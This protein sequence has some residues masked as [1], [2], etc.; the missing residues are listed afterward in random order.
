[1][2]LVSSR[3]APFPLGFLGFKVWGLGLRNEGLG[4]KVWGS[5]FRLSGSGFRVLSLELRIRSL[6]FRDLVMRDVYEKAQGM[7]KVQ[8]YRDTVRFRC[9]YAYVTNT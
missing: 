1:M 4:C 6:S 7:N 5:R 8:A 9:A 3:Q 2:S